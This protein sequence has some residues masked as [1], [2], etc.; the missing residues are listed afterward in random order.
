MVNEEHKKTSTLP[1]SDVIKIVLAILTQSA[2]LFAWGAS[3]NARVAVLESRVDAHE[4]QMRRGADHV[5]T[6]QGPTFGSVRKP[7]AGSN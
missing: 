5:G 7:N 6:I 2:A 4:S 1:T 3:I